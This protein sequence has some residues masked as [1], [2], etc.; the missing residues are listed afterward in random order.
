METT[1]S[2]DRVKAERVAGYGSNFVGEGWVERYKGSPVRE[3][4]LRASVV[5]D[6]DDAQKAM[7]WTLENR[8]A[9]PYSFTD[10]NRIIGV[11]LVEGQPARV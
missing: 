2:L 4:I 11:H 3:R 10:S 8:H 9:Y 1:L 7:A 5:L 6:D